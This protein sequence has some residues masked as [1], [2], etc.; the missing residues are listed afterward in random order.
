MPNATS[1]P[2]ASVRALAAQFETALQ[3]Y[4]GFFHGGGADDEAAAATDAV[5]AIAQKIVAVPGTDISIM[6][7]KARVYRWAES[8]DLEKLA[9]E[10]GSDW[11]SEAVLASLFRD[12]GVADLETTPGPT[13]MADRAPAQHEEAHGE[14]REILILATEF[15]DLQAK[16]SLIRTALE[17][18]EVAFAAIMKANGYKK[19][20]EW[21]HRSEYW[22]LN[23]ELSD[24]CTRETNLVES[25]IK[26]SR[27]HRP[28]SRRS[29]PR[30]RRI[31]II[32]GK[33]LKRI[34][35]GRFL[36]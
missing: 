5:K 13:T 32:S 23:D 6:R 35:I 20:E 22:A 33:S 24:L 29:P 16:T 26:P 15:Q 3:A 28:E 4:S 2:D 36:S 30:S 27:R 14:N 31:R 34:V 21:G 9:A 7:L 10:G 25:M 12:L 8:T 17:P 1:Y 18:L 11:P 19:A